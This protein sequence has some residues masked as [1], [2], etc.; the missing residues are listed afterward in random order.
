M[1]KQIDKQQEVLD[2]L[3]SLNPV[4]IDVDETGKVSDAGAE[5]LK[6]RIKSEVNK[7]KNKGQ[8]NV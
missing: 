2:W 8:N 6:A 4:V 7:L 1:S 3:A 5:E